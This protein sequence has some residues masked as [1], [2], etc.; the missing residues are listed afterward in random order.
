[1]EVSGYPKKIL[2]KFRQANE[3]RDYT[4]YVW[5]MDAAAEDKA[6]SIFPHF[7][8]LRDGAI[9]VDA[10]SGTGKVGE[11]AAKQFREAH[12]YLQDLS[13][14]LMEVADE[15]MALARL[16]YGDA[17]TEVFP[18]NS[19]DI[20]FFSTVGHEMESEQ[21]G[22]MYRAMVV[23]FRELK[24]SGQV[25]V[26]DFAKPERKE[27][28][29]MKIISGV[30]ENVPKDTK[31]EDI[32]Y[33]KLSTRALLERFCLEFGDGGKFSYEEV[34]V[35]GEGYIKIEPEW[36]AEFYLR[37]DYTG[38]WRQELH[39]KYTYW[40]P[41]EAVRKLEDIGF[42]NVQVFPDPNTYI[43]N[44]RL[45]GK[46]AL[47][48]M[49]EDGVLQGFDFPT[50]HMVFVGQKPEEGTRSEKISRLPSVDYKKLFASIKIDKGLVE[51]NG[52]RFKVKGEDPLVGTKKLIFR[53]KENPD[54]ILKVIRSDTRNDHNVFKSM[55]QTIERQRILREMKTP[56]LAILD[57]DQKGPPY[58]YLIQEAAPE[59]AENVADL[60]KEDKL[61][62]EDIAQIA[63]IVNKYEKG[64]TWQ[65]DTN[66]FS[67]FRVKRKDGTT[68]MVY[69]SSKV[70]KYDERWE[71]KR[72]GL[73]QWLNPVY[74]ENSRRYSSAI[75]KA[76]EHEGL[77]RKWPHGDEQIDIWKKYLDPSV[78]PQG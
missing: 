76:K 16:T 48:E 60:I 14:E 13:F 45:H 35:N 46:I 21:P 19:I 55:Y 40:T 62:E 17:T 61:S 3:N 68:E 37:K 6:N 65:L 47:Y 31:I 66:P 58:R 72:I 57:Y 36:A 25:V 5:Q 2:E 43:L 39:E 7:G 41:S 29:Y 42:I 70:Y 12:V 56:H 78:Q 24:P 38:N 59:G 18:P 27:P 52:E 22:G 64:K 33:N 77:I 73:L 30:G 32:D 10:G 63:K 53:L 23:A 9:I 67:W 75:P 50:T 4:T 28:I 69:A 26:R 8:E 15:N 11:L 74:V 44:N 34:K 1:M 51:I 49:G 54:R 20:K 71:F